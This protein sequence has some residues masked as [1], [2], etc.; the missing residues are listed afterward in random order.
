MNNDSVDTCYKIKES[1]LNR[2]KELAKE[3]DL[4]YYPAEGRGIKIFEKIPKDKMTF[5]M[6]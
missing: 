1:K 2:L 6:Y 4:D 3:L 5:N